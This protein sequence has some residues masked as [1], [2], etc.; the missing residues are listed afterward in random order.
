MAAPHVAGAAAVLLQRHPSWTPPQVKSALV[1]TG[2]PVT[3]G[4]GDEVATTREG[5]GMVDLEAAD[6]PL[7][8]AAP[9][10]VTFGLLQPGREA[11]RQIALTDAGGAAGTWSVAVAPQGGG[12]AVQVRAAPSVAVPGSLTVTATA[13]SAA[14]EATGFIVL[15]RGDQRRRIPYW[16]LVSRPALGRH[17]RVSLARAGTY[18]GNTRAKQALV[19]TYRYP[20]DL[21]ALRVTRVLGGPEQVFRLRLRRRVANFGV[22]ILERGRGVRVEPRVVAAGNENRLAGDSALPINVNAYLNGY[23]GRVPAAGALLPEP[24]AYDIVFDSANRAGAGPFRFRLWINDVTPPAVRLLGRSVRRGGVL[25]LTMSDRGAGV[26]PDSV[27]A[28]LDDRP[29]RIQFGG[30]RAAVALGSLGRGTH[31]LV[32]R[33]SDWQE[34]RNTENAYRI[35]PNTRILRTTIRVR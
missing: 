12:G 10:G 1:L 20:D 29:A 4:G 11:S 31:R 2:R 13:G 27:S 32:V 16:L 14:G 6:D 30:G 17:S 35:L 22:R 26:W 34:T 8:F 7:V 19:S 3:E 5:G 25:R 21:S 9:S 24:G 15:T 28:T 33:A 18:R 23:H